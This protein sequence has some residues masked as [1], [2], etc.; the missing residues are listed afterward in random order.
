MG[1]I[2]VPPHQQV[3]SLHARTV[4]QDCAIRR[5]EIP[6]PVA[7]T[8][9]SWWQSSGAVGSVLAAF[10][11]GCEVTR[12]SLLEDIHQTRLANGYF[13]PSGDPFTRGDMMPENRLALDMLSTFVINYGKES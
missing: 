9:A 10:A 4:I 6:A 8:I 5:E 12:L 11:S 2:Q 3:P 7:V 13:G 1:T